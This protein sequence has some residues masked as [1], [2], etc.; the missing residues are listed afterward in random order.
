MTTK[1]PKAIK[2]QITTYFFQQADNHRYLNKSRPE[3]RTFIEAMVKDPNVGGL[4]SEFM[5]KAAVRV[6]I[7]DAL[8]NAYAKERRSRPRDIQ[9]ILCRR[10]TGPIT[11]IEYKKNDNVSL[12]RS[13]EG[14]LVAVVRTSHLKWETGLRKLLLYVAAAPGLPPADGTQFEMVLLIFQDGVPVNDA[15]KNLIENALKLANT[16]CIWG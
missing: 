12:H 3:N 10:Y 16:S 6:Y 8:L 4:L 13:E 11:E 14:N 5:P 2:Q 15:D 9:H 1:V 7:K